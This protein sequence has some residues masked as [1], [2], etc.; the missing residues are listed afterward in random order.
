MPQAKCCD[1]SWKSGSSLPAPSESK[2]GAMSVIG[3]KRTLA[4]AQ[5]I[6]ASDP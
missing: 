5:P 4:I 6:S 1:S 2:R 3:T